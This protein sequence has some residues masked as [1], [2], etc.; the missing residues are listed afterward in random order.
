MAAA[1]KV[2]RQAIGLRQIDLATRCGLSELTITRFERTG[3]V[4]L[5]VFARIVVA[6]GMSESL[7]EALNAEASPRTG[8][9]TVEEFL[10]AGQ[11]RQRVRLRRIGAKI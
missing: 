11:K 6:L 5:G 2:K 9:R 10:R 7:V 1:C 3:Q 4:G 8:S